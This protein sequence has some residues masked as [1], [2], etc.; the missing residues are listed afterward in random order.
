M[1]KYIKASKTNPYELLGYI[2]D[3]MGYYRKIHLNTYASSIEKAISNFRHQIYTNPTYQGYRLVE[4]PNLMNVRLY[5]G[6]QYNRWPKLPS[7]AKLVND[8][9]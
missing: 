2:I 7:N 4:D 1:K 3:D 6:P 5:I 8:S 9:R